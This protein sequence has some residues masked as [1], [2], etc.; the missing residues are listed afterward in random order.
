M[1]AAARKIAL[2]DKALKALKPAPAGKRDRIWDALMPGL[3]VRITDKGKKSFVVVRRLPGAAQPTWATLGE[4][5][6]LSLAEAREKARQALGAI[7]AGE[8]PREREVVRREAVKEAARSAHP[9]TLGTIAEKFIA[10]HL[11]HLRTASEVERLI[12]REIIP[13]L[14]DRPIGE[15]RRRDIIALVEAIHTRDNGGRGSL[16]TGGRYAA[17]YAF[18]VLSK[19][20][21]WAVNRDVD[22]LEANPCSGIRVSELLGAAKVR[23]RVLSESEIR[24]VWRAAGQMGYP[25]GD[26]IKLLLLTGQRLDEI[27]A[28]RWIEIDRDNALLIIPAERMKGKQTHVVPLC[29]A[30]LALLESLPRFTAGDFIFSTTG[31]R[32]PV[33]GFSK[34]QARARQLAGIPNWRLH[35]LRRTMRTGLAQTGASVFVAELIIAH[36]QSG[37]H[38]V[39]DLH[40]YD[41]DRRAALQRWEER[42]LAIV[43]EPHPGGEN[44][45]PM[46]RQAAE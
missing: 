33:S 27:A 4:Y 7:V 5:P 32:R 37:V 42:L 36:R 12:R 21:G 26:L 44:V 6:V 46:R 34:A 35:D 20:F 23:D 10:G 15:I 3:A 30:A 17:R 19:L 40:R 24:A 16:K 25:F 31:G 1:P 29:P 2:T 43:G 38:A 8:H 11:P 45:V 39:Y 9:H 14:G 22:G 18:A 28:A 13:V 41:E